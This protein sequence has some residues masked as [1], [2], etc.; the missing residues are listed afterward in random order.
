MKLKKLLVLLCIV[1]LC[2][3]S[4]MALSI[5]GSYVPATA[6]RGIWHLW[7]DLSPDIQ[8]YYNNWR[9]G[10]RRNALFYH[11][12]KLTIDI[13]PDGNPPIYYIALNSPY[14]TNSIRSTATWK[15]SEQTTHVVSQVEL[16]IG[17]KKNNVVLDP[18]D[19]ALNADPS[20]GGWLGISG[21]KPEDHTIISQDTRIEVEFYLYT[22]SDL[23]SYAK[24]SPIYFQDVNIQMASL[25]YSDDSSAQNRKD[26]ILDNSTNEFDYWGGMKVAPDEETYR[27]DAEK[28]EKQTLA[29]SV[30]ENTEMIDSGKPGV[31]QPVAKLEIT[32]NNNKAPSKDYNLKIAMYDND[33]VGTGHSLYYL[34]LDDDKSNHNAFLVT[35]DVAGQKTLNDPNQT[36][37]LSVP[38]G[39]TV[40]I[41]KLVNASFVNT[42][43]LSLP[44]GNY[45]DTVYV[46]IIT[47]DS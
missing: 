46:D 16:A 20:W 42:D 14:S 47:G 7:S 6:E 43:N 38:K 3:M 32:T 21:S 23:K 15:N 12:G 45:R 13:K 10:N 34:H 25:Q 26:L 33:P 41:R 37:T 11:L 35:L 39:E 27:S 28:P 24:D 18:R 31:K 4:L 22:L 5:S 8:A 19:L 40:P 30:V 2:S 9:I 44:A 1:L 29:L 36:I 17:I